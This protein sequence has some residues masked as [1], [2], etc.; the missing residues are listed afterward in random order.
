MSKSPRSKVKEEIS[1]D[2]AVLL[3][4]Q[5][6][7]KEWQGKVEKRISTIEDL[8][9]KET[10]LGNLVRGFDQD[11]MIAS[12]RNR[13]NKEADEKEKLFSGSSYTVWLERNKDKIEKLI[14]KVESTS[15]ATTSPV[16]STQS[17]TSTAPPA[18][19]MKR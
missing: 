5:K 14:P 2:L 15:A 9:L 16:E 4:H 17:S 12:R 19:K 18:K 3:K 8:Y 10:P 1:E 11:A 13:E 6:Q 7:I